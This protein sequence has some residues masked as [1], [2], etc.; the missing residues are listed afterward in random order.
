MLIE[1][2]VLAGVERVYSLRL[3]YRGIY[4]WNERRLELQKDYDDNDKEKEGREYCSNYS[5]VD[6]EKRN[7][8]HVIALEE[9]EGKKRLKKKKKA[10]RG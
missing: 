1:F 9:E 8:G 2:A 3:P 5:N 7:Y 6:D 4:S 10:K